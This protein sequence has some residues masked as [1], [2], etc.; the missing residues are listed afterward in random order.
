ML[1][2]NL[3]KVV[4]MKE[5]N[6]IKKDMVEGNFFIKMVECMMVIGYKIKCKDMVLCTMTQEKLHIKDNGEMINLMEKVNF[7][8][9]NQK[10]YKISL[11]IVVMMMWMNIGNIMRDNLF[12]I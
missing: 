12:K 4:D 8:I 10:Y 9:N 2:R 11:I 3:N 7:I 6:L 1:F 5:L